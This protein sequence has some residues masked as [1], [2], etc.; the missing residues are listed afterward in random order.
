M[1]LAAEP[2][3]MRASDRLTRTSHHQ[4]E[5]RCHRLPFIFIGS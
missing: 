2:V 3:D 5:T 4:S 1:W